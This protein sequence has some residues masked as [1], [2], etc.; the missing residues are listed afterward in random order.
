MKRAVLIALIAYV[1]MAVALLYSD[2]KDFLWTHPWWH[3]L[4]VAV[5]GIAVPILAWLELRHSDEANTLRTEANEHRAAANRLQDRIASLVVELDDERNKHLQQIAKNTEKPV[6]NAERNAN[7]LR[8]H[9]RATVAV[10]E[11]QNAWGDRTEIV[12]VS[13]DNIVTLFTPRGYTSS[14]AWCV[15]VNCGDLEITDIPQ[16]AC[17]LRLKVLKRY[18]PD[19]Q[20]GEITKWEDRF[21]SA[22][23]LNFTK[24]DAA[25]YATFVKPGS[26]E[27]RSLYVFT[28]NDGANSFSLEAS[29]GE[30][31][32]G[33]NVEISKRFMMMHVEY[34]AAGFTRSS[35]GTGS[36][37]HRLFI[38]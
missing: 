18:G 14:R 27:R 12:E 21:Q 4:L 34:L 24:G 20:L 1:V 36:Q 30:K 38:W 33:D 31:A 6:T 25:Y 10:S 29:T 17:P 16:G 15:G 37:P 22:A 35:A 5:P 2:I 9:L 28:S 7:T 3:S 23:A 26:P 11:G 32:T 19:V 8:K 13:E